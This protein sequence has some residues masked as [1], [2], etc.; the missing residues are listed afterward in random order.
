LGGFSAGSGI[1]VLGM[2]VT[3]TT[4]EEVYVKTSRLALAVAMTISAAT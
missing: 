2:H 4:I 3:G 1:I